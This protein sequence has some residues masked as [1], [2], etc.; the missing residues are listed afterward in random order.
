MARRRTTARV[1]AST[2]YLSAALLFLACGT[3]RQPASPQPVTIVFKHAKHP[4]SEYLS[5]LIQRFEAENPGIH[6]RE[7]ILPSDSDEQ[8]QFYVINLA[9]HSRQVD[10]IDLDVIWVQ[11]F[12]RAGWLQPLESNISKSELQQLN[13]PALQPDQFH[14][15]LYAVPWFLDAGV[16]YYRRDLLDKYGLQPPRTY[17]ELV[18]QA[19]T[20]MAGEA[21]P[22]LSGFVW[23]GMQYEGLVTVALEFVRGNGGQLLR[24][25]R[26]ELTDPAT[27]EA[28][29]FMG[30]LVHRYHVTP[31]MVTTLSEESTR[32]VFQTGRAVF[33]RNWPYAWSLLNAPGSPV[34]GRV[35]FTMVPH[36]DEHQSVP[37][38]GGYHLGV[39]A[40]SEHKQ[41]AAAFVR[42]MV[43]FESQKQISLHLGVLPANMGVYS[44]AEAVERFPLLPKMLPI[45]QQV[46]SRPVTPY[47]PTDLASSATATQRRSGCGAF[48]AAGNAK[49]P[50]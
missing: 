35:G 15:R 37:T 7:E 50:G 6:V 34:A 36:F 33:M 13:Q 27:V 32:F 42:F 39:N 28:V 22:R 31:P 49:G 17:P 14:D 38:L 8:H 45:L 21:D 40:F 20:I 3:H 46:R 5:E 4:H 29:G 1:L 10:V 18:K 47:Y 41:Q 11:E 12:A 43:G 9:A 16:L 23:Q 24:H 19:R 25:G 30:D 2:V 44:D 26:P 48:A